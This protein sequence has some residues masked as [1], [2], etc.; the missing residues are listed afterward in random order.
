MIL[1]VTGNIAE[2]KIIYSAHI[3]QYLMSLSIIQYITLIHSLYILMLM[4]FSY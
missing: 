2:I 1:Y 3:I 4:A